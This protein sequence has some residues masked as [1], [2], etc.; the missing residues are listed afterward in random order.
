MTLKFQKITEDLYFI[1]NAAWLC[2]LK[3]MII[4]E[5]QAT[6]VQDGVSSVKPP[7]ILLNQENIPAVFVATVNSTTQK[8][9]DALLQRDSNVMSF[10]PHPNQTKSI[11][12]SGHKIEIWTQRGKDATYPDFAGTHTVNLHPGFKLSQIK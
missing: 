10:M 11:A 7:N 2:H 3:L 5:W 9:K 4:Q 6:A 12:L 1:K 8:V